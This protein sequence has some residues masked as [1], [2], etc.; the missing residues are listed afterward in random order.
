[1]TPWLYALMASGAAVAAE[2]YYRLNPDKTWGL[3]LWPGVLLALIVNYGIWGLTRTQSLVELAILF[4]LFTA[5]FRVAITLSRGESVSPGVWVAFG[6]V[7][8]ASLVKGL[9]K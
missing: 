9:W 4:S 3:Q 2:F 8:L 1:V 7:V 5:S 6:L